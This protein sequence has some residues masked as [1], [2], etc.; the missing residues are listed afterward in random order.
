MTKHTSKHKARRMA[1]RA[2]RRGFKTGASPAYGS[3]N[4]MRY[5][6]RDHSATGRG[7]RDTN[8]E[9]TNQGET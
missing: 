4:L 2:I 9:D 6:Y 8:H 3:R 7:M 1:R 5:N